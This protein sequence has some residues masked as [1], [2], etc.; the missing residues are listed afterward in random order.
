VFPRL[1]KLCLSFRIKLIEAGDT[2][3][4]AVIYPEVLKYLGQ[5]SHIV[6]LAV[7]LEDVGAG[8]E[9]WF[10]RG[11]GDLLAGGDCSRKRR[12]VSS[13]RPIEGDLLL[14]SRLP[15]LDSLYLLSASQAAEKIA[16]SACFPSPSVTQRL[17]HLPCLYE[18]TRGSKIQEYR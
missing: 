15:T 11:H 10:V 12:V 13:I 7:G 17:S 5:I 3:T 4:F 9:D 6:A 1:Y 2:C 14:A 8:V 16:S 18:L